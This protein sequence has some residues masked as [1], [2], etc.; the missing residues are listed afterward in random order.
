QYH[1][2][3]AF[4]R[5]SDEFFLEDSWVATEAGDFLIRVG[6]FKPP[7]IYEENVKWHDQLAAER[8][9]ATTFFTQGY[10]QGIEFQYDTR[11]NFR[12]KLALT[13]GIRT[14]NFDFDQANEADIAFTGRLDYLLRGDWDTVTD[15]TSEYGGA[16]ALRI[17]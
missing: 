5:S 11:Q 2:Q 4:S 6:Q 3:G 9:N 8:S 13:D 14:P 7:F 16:E 10:S 17:G 15:F 1:V 12:S